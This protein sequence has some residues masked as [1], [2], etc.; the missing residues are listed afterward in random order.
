MFYKNR[1][2]DEAWARR[3]PI[4]DVYVHPK[5]NGDYTSGFDIAILICGDNLGSKNLTTSHY[6]A[7]AP[8]IDGFTFEIDP[9]KVLDLDI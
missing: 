1:A 3:Y 8:V 5:Y 6:A 7:E 9:N 2:G 4:T